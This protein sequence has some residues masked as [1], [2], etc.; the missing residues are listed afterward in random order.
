MQRWSR[1]VLMAVK[2]TKTVLSRHRTGETIPRSPKGEAVATVARWLYQDVHLGGTIDDQGEPASLVHSAW[3]ALLQLTQKRYVSAGWRFTP[4]ADG[5]VHATRD[6]VEVIV[7]G[8]QM[9]EWVVGEGCLVLYRFRPNGLY[10]WHIFLSCNSAPVYAD[11]RLYL[12]DLADEKLLPELVRE[13]DAMSLSWSGKIAANATS[14]RP[15]RLVL[16][17]DEDSFQSVAD[18]VARVRRLTNGSEPCRPGFS[19]EVAPGIFGA[20]SEP[21]FRSSH[22][23]LVSE[24]FAR[25][26]VGQQAH[27]P[28]STELGGLMQAR[29]A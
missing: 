27:D 5:D 19:S 7:R 29:E 26:L 9:E 8:D 21:G 23:S 17:T 10:G 6:G 1:S 25:I 24:H 2:S 22:G 14:L 15:D 3:S 20:R 12:P 28:S 13:L 18:A 11:I 16:Y 4:S